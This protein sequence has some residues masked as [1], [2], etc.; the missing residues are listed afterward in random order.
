MQRS[1]VDGCSRRRWK[2]SPGDPGGAL[3]L[4]EDDAE[5][6]GVSVGVPPDTFGECEKHCSLRGRRGFVLLLFYY[7]V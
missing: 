7:S 6:D 5:L 2:D 1:G 3:V 4:A